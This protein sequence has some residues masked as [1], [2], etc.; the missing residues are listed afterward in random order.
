VAQM[1]VAEL[2]DYIMVIVIQARNRRLLCPFGVRLSAGSLLVHNKRLA[3]G[4]FVR[5]VALLDLP[6]QAISAFKS[7]SWLVVGIAGSGECAPAAACA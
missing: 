3:P 7:V 5:N 1:Q 4:R 6:W 2:A